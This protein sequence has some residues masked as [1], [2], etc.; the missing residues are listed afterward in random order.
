MH[1]IQTA[2]TPKGSEVANKWPK[3]EGCPQYGR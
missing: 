3:K 1:E 2:L